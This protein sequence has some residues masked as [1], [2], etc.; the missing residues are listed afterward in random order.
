MRILVLGGTRFAGAFFVEKALAAGHQV[1][2]FHRGVTGSVPPGVTSVLGDRDPKIRPGLEQLAGSHWDAVVDF[3]TSIPLQVEHAIRTLG[4]I[5]RYVFVSSVSAYSELSE[6]GCE[7]SWPLSE[8]A[9]LEETVLSGERYSALKSGC[10]ARVQHHF[11]ERAWILRPGLMAGPRDHSDRMTWWPWRIAQGGATL[12][13]TQAQ[14][15]LVDARD[16]AGFL[17]LGLERGLSGVHNVVGPSMPLEQLLAGCEVLVRALGRQPARL[18][19]MEGAWLEEQGVEPWSQ[20][21]L[22]TGSDPAEFGWTRVSAARA[23]RDGLV[24]REVECTLRDTLAWA[25]ENRPG[26]LSTG[27]DPAPEAKLISAW[28]AQERAQEPS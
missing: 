15:Q 16:V 9:G 2:A 28:L 1:T 23:L 3:S 19:W 22:W 25:L 5:E 12:A 10:E 17:L 13:P 14:S 8:P 24:C 21:P 4:R 6:A 26:G 27:L 11:G 7:E 20:L 18:H